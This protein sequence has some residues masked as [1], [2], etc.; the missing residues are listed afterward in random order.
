MEDRA[1]RLLSRDAIPKLARPEFPEHERRRFR[2]PTCLGGRAQPSSPKP[3][4]SPSSSSSPKPSSIP[5]P[6]APSFRENTTLWFRQSE[7]LENSV[8][9][10]PVREH[11]VF[12]IVLAVSGGVF[13]LA[14]LG[15]YTVL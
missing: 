8:E 11:P 1:S 14:L 7:D 6:E 15:S 10:E 12:R 4:S 13:L 2:L 5:A 3:S 9:L